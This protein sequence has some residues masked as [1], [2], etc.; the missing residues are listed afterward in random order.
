MLSAFLLDPVVG[1]PRRERLMILPIHDRDDLAECE[2]DLCRSRYRLIV[3][4]LKEEIS[5][6]G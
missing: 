5:E 6:T 4:D 3:V 2:G 1:C